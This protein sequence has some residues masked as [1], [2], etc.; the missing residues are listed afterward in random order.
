MDGAKCHI[1]LSI[2]L[3]AEEVKIALFCLSSNTTHKLQPLHKSFFRS[4]EINWETQLNIFFKS[5][6]YGDRKLTKVRFGK[7][8]S[9]TWDASMTSKNIQSGKLIILFERLRL[10]Y[11]FMFLIYNKF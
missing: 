2:V 3:K 11:S 6:D 8:L 9:L 4:F 5:L 7:V 10:Q 1:D